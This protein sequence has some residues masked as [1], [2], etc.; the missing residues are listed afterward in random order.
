MSDDSRSVDSSASSKRRDNERTVAG[1]HRRMRRADREIVDSAQIGEIISRCD[2]VDVAYVDAEGL[3]MVPL[4]FGYDYD[5]AS[6][7]LTLWIHSAAHGRKLDA[8]RAADNQL[9]VSFAMRTDCEVIEGRTACNWG[10]AFTSVIGNGIASIVD[11]LEERRRGLQLLMMHQAHMPHVEF[12]DAQ[13]NA[14][15]VWK[16]E[17]TR[18]TAKVHAKPS[19]AHTQRIA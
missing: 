8:I 13:V 1:G 17:A 2:I 11:D 19:R 3:T 5:S 16:I 10:E 15:T 12:T 4:N 7:S 6:G 14:V 9:P 18:L